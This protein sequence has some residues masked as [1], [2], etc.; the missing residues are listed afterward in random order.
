MCN[1]L[2]LFFLILVLC[3]RSLKNISFS[4]FRPY[5]NLIH[6]YDVYV[7]DNP[8]LPDAEWLYYP[9]N[10]SELSNNAF[11]SGDGSIV[12]HNLHHGHTYYVRINVRKKDGEVLRSPSIY[13]FK[14]MGKSK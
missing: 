5:S 8:D 2:L 11:G 3:M 1:R 4:C 12:L 6:S 7:T 14:T 9:A 13:R 10:V